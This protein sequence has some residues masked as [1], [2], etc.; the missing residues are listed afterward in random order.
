MLRR[1]GASRSAARYRVGKGAGPSI[2]ATVV[3]ERVFA[4]QL[5]HDRTSDII[6]THCR[7]A[8]ECAKP[9]VVGVGHR[10]YLAGHAFRRRRTVWDSAARPARCRSDRTGAARTAHL[11]LEPERLARPRPAPRTG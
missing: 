6:D 8:C 5:R 4:A 7:A 3:G 10:R 9:L 1:A 2:R 11:L